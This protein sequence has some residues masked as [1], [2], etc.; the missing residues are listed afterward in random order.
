MTSNSTKKSFTQ[1]L[2]LEMHL[3]QERIHNGPISAQKLARIFLTLTKMSCQ[4]TSLKDTLQH[5]CSIRKRQK[6]KK[7]HQFWSNNT[8]FFSFFV[9]FCF[10]FDTGTS[11]RLT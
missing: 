7:K 3:H 6:I 4:D 11:F 5:S 8:D 2:L 10:L 9:F 1:E